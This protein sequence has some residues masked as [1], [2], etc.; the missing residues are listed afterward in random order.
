[1]TILY[2]NSLAEADPE[3]VKCLREEF[4]N[5]KV[6]DEKF[7]DTL[8]TCKNSDYDIS[9][10]I[11]EKSSKPKV[12]TGAKKKKRFGITGPSKLEGSTKDN[13]FSLVYMFFYCFRNIGP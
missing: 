3:F 6:L 1:M 5:V 12:P 2:K 11:D 9:G 4:P 8:D 10:N 7:P 13:N